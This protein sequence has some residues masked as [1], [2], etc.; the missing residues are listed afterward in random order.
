MT[1]I[2]SPGM[3]G[4]SIRLNVTTAGDRFVSIE[5]RHGMTPTVI[6]TVHGG[7]EREALAEAYQV[8]SAA[9]AALAVR[10]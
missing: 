2:T 5:G 1:P 3:R 4:L 9:V 7:T 6:A 10:L 8:L